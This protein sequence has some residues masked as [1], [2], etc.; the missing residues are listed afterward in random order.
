MKNSWE[1]ILHC[2]S[3]SE[4][5]PCGGLCWL[6]P[7]GSSVI[8]KTSITYRSV[9]DSGSSWLKP[10]YSLKSN[11]VGCMAIRIRQPGLELSGQLLPF[12]F[13]HS[14]DILFLFSTGHKQWMLLIQLTLK[15]VRCIPTESWS[16]ERK[17]FCRSSTVAH[18]L[19]AMWVMLDQWEMWLS[20][21]LYQW[22]ITSTS[23]D[24]KASPSSHFS[25]INDIFQKRM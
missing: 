2:T 15:A 1:H 21:G 16:G 8:F 7:A 18:R 14:S 25:V 3:H 20:S 23:E 17:L 24:G 4:L 13:L 6:S 10:Y 19:A 9:T 22:D 5:G 11:L 12:L